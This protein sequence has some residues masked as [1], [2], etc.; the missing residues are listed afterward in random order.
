MKRWAVAVTVLLS[1]CLTGCATVFDG[2]YLSVEPHQEPAQQIPVKNPTAT[3]YAQLYKA[4]IALIENG[5]TESVITVSDYSKTLLDEDMRLAVETALTQHPIAAYA[6]EDVTYELGKSG[7]RAALAVKISYVH[8]RTEIKKIKR[9][10]EMDDARKAITDALSQCEP[11][12]VLRVDRYRNE[13]FTQVVEKF[14]FENPQ[15]VMETPQ[16]GVHCY[17]ETGVERVLEIR[18]AYQTSR[19]SLKAMQEQ[20]RAVFTSASLYVNMEAAPLE[21]YT[22]LSSFLME[23]Y[24]YT[25][26]T[27]ITPTYSLL[28]YG[29]G[30]SRAFATVYSAMCRQVQLECQVVSGTKNGESRYWNI[31][32]V[33]DVYYHVDLLAGEFRMRPD[34]EMTGYVWDYSGY[35]RCGND[36]I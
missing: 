27:S 36:E 9:V 34:K 26:E 11:G 15:I 1:L 4:L 12:L 29:V 24:S 8:D 6:V 22:Q 17:P 19:D 13:D 21:K 16:V 20:V 2:S 18:F 5:T 23:R 14:C 28:R 31:V 32:K 33:D 3:N 35:P 25:F 30:D 7:G 10:P